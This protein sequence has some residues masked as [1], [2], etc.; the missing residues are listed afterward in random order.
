MIILMVNMMTMVIIMIS[1]NSLMRTF[2]F[3]GA[4][5]CYFSKSKK[6]KKKR[7]TLDQDFFLKQLSAWEKNN[8]NKIENHLKYNLFNC[9][10]Y[11]YHTKNKKKKKQLNTH[12]LANWSIH[13][14]WVPKANTSIHSIVFGGLAKKTNVGNKNT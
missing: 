13:S 10:C 9:F 7:R 3:I 6:K 11:F 12:R 5:A 1:C 14:I 4:C 8:N 2:N